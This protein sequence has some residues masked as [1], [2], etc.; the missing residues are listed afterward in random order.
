MKFQSNHPKILFHMR[1]LR[2]TFRVSVLRETFSHVDLSVLQ[3]YILCSGN[4]PSNSPLFAA[5]QETYLY[6]NI[7]SF[8]IVQ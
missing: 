7:N 1:I 4:I 3:I 8:L 2:T 5:L 6:K